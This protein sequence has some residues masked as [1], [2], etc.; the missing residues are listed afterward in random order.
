M[1]FL[2]PLA[3]LA[4]VAAVAIV[5]LYF[6]KTRRPAHQVSSTLWWR[7][8]TLDRQAA[9]P[10]Q[11]LKPSWLLVLQL[12]AA[13]LLV[14]A[15]MEPA[16]ASANALTG[17]TIVIIDTSETMAATDVAPSR[18][19]QAVSQARA[20]VG[21]LGPQARMTLIDMDADPTVLAL[22]DGDRQ[23]LLHALGQL[24]ATDGPADLQ[25]ALQL[26]LAA[27]GPHSTRTRLVV[28]SDGITEPLAEPARVPFPLEYSRVGESGQNVGITS[29]SVVR[30]RP[31]W[32]PKPM[33]RTSGRWRPTSR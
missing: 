29:L 11:R 24:Q 22:G 5:A 31:A 3:G 4:G 16:L 32:W 20:L 28:L 14:A 10:W 9:V 2:D 19:A 25:G 8:L 13:A 26:A 18:L 30:G 33:S 7:P 1:T 12:L 23:D 21:R 6:L 17:Q 15:L 27:A